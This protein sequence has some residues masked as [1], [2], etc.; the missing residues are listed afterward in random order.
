MAIDHPSYNGNEPITKGQA[1]TW[2]YQANEGRTWEGTRGKGREG[3]P[4]PY[5]TR[6]LAYS[7][8]AFTFKCPLSV[9][10]FPTIPPFWSYTL[11]NFCLLLIL[12]PPLHSSKPQD[13]EPGELKQKLLQHQVLLIKTFGIYFSMGQNL[14]CYP[15]LWFPVCN[16]K[17]PNK[18]FC[19]S[20]V[21]PLFF[22]QQ[23][24]SHYHE[25]K[26]FQNSTKLKSSNDGPCYMQTKY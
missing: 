2:T 14:G 3:R 9:E 1:S 7:S 19:F 21:L 15:N 18:Y 13:K 23:P 6:T 10:S 8:Q 24:Q 26:D 12:C 11:I 16:S 4:E 25:R 17:T 22:S 5:K 20:S